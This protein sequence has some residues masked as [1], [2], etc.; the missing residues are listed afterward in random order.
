[1][2][3]LADPGD[4]DFPGMREYDLNGADEFLIE[5]SGRAAQRGCLDLHGGARYGEPLLLIGWHAEASSSHD[6][7]LA[8][9]TH[10]SHRAVT[11]RS[12]PSRKRAAGPC[13]TPSR[14]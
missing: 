13:D 6:R 7:S 3:G 10:A 9:M 11:G 14:S 2:A 12:G 8:V 5:A 1:M 4:H